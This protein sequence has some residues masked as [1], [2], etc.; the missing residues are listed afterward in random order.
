MKLLQISAWLRK[1][2]FT[3]SLL[4]PISYVTV[5]AT[6]NVNIEPF[7]FNPDPVNINVNDQVVWTWVSD[8]H[9]TTS[10][11][12]GLWDSGLHNSGF[13]FTNKFTSAGS[14]PYSCVTHGFTG[15][16]NVQAPLRL[17]I[18][19]SGPLLD[20]SWPVATG[21]LQA[22]TN[23]LGSSWADV[24]NSTGTNH[25]VLPVDPAKTSV[26]FRLAVP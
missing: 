11:T 14:F 15:T 18:R 9:T 17:T 6:I 19:L 13:V 2:V 26:F 25:V 5:A 10:D 4:L 7:D 12:P 8:F 23:S 20:I 3:G 16:V 21:H 24:P 22:K 1:M